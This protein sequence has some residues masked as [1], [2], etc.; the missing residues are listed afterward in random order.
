MNK[1]YP[2]NISGMVFYIN[3]DAFTILNN[4]LKTLEAHYL[5]TE[6]GAEIISD[7]ESRIAELLSEKVN[8]HKQ[9]IS[10]EEVEEIIKKL[11]RVE[12]FEDNDGQE[13]KEESDSYSFKE[14]NKRT[15]KKRK[16]FRDADDGVIAGVCS[17]ISH[18]IGVDVIF[19]RLIFLLLIIGGSIGFWIYIILWSISS[20]ARTR[21][22]K[23]EMKGEPIN[24]TNIEK[25]IREEFEN[26]RHSINNP[27]LSRKLKAFINSL[28][29]SIKK[30]LNKF[31]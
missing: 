16:F 28:L 4:Y 15:R 19:V 26:I 9:A 8:T 10:K 24:L 31:T 13:T 22:E 2:I 25:D 21:S 12:D 14:A 3:E 29:G 20:Y 6:D 23:L 30:L 5:K 27:N 17:G 1:T 11:G 18:Y 7:I